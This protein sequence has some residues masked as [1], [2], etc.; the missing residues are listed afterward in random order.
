MDATLLHE[1]MITKKWID[2]GF[3]SEDP[4]T[5]FKGVG[6]LGLISFHYFVTRR[7]K[8]AL[9]CFKH[10]RNKDTEYR[11][12]FF[13]INVV[14]YMMENFSVPEICLHFT[15]AISE[16]EVL[17]IFNGLYAIFFQKLDKYWIASPLSVSLMNFNTVMV[18][19]KDR[20]F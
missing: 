14:Q 20:L 4:T 19:L 11:F 9:E 1:N 3:Q 2:I 17:L 15:T 16:E 7:T 18:N 13:G 5:D 10:A 12:A 6:S 8:N